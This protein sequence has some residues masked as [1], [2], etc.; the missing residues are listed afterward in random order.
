MN[1]FRNIIGKCP[2]SLL[3]GFTVVTI[4]GSA[5]ITFKDENRKSRLDIQERA[6]SA[7]AVYDSDYSDNLELS[8]IGNMLERKLLKRFDTDGSGNLNGD[9]IGEFD[10]FIDELGK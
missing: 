7:I 10:K 3:F 5:Y 6:S 4:L 8:E 1:Y 2:K 9:E